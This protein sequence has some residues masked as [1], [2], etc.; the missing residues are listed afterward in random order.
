MY[1]RLSIL[2]LAIAFGP[3]T[4]R[5]QD[6]VGPGERRFNQFIYKASHN[7]YWG[8]PLDY[9]IDAL[10]MWCLELD[11]HW[12]HGDVPVVRHHCGD[13]VIVRTLAEC[14]TEAARAQTKRDRIT[15]LYLEMKP[16]IAGDPLWNCHK[17]WPGRAAYRAALQSVIESNL[18]VG[19]V[20]RSAEF[21]N[22][23]Q[24]RWPSW[25]EL[26]R[27][28]YQWAVVLDEAIFGSADDDYFFGAEHPGG[29]PANPPPDAPP[30]SVMIVVDGGCDVDT[31][32]QTLPPLGDRWMGRAYPGGACAFDCSQQDGNYWN[33]LVILG[34]SFVATDCRPNAHTYDVRTHSPA[35]L[36]VQRGGN[37]A[38][39]GTLVFPYRNLEA[40][41]SRASPMV[42]VTLC[43]PGLYDVTNGLRINRPLVLRASAG[44]VA[45]I[46]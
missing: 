9:Q 34:Y 6:N 3:G 33:N 43:E 41:L 31:T 39:Y 35:P 10:N 22:R 26:S 25:Q 32:D 4:T 12:D 38:E 21:K 11:L 42:P 1:L 29:S 5:G 18:G 45:E 8:E 16:H 23:D 40:A 14:L 24:S 7:S 17:S 44:V 46:R 15:L 19:T 27:R 37:D 13:G 28:G 2:I 30:N 20:Y 36:F